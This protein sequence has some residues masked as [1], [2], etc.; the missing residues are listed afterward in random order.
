M[1][2]TTIQVILKKRLMG[3]GETKWA[4]VDLMGLSA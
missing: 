1:G 2:H 3:Q 4:K